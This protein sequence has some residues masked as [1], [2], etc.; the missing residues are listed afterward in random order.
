MI[1]Q[2]Q[3]PG[4]VWSCLLSH[5]QKE[6]SGVRYWLLPRTDSSHSQDPK[7]PENC[8]CGENFLTSH[9]VDFANWFR[10]G[11]LLLHTLISPLIF[12]GACR[13]EQTPRNRSI[14]IKL[15]KASDSQIGNTFQ[16]ILCKHDGRLLISS[17][18]SCLAGRGDVPSCAV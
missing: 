18:G 2:K 17:N 12:A 8:P 9:A 4:T 10:T 11:F 7:G 6:V 1:T 14:S 13:I 15:R 3:P 16:V 5:F